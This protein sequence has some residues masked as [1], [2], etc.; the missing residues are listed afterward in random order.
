MVIASVKVWEG[1]GK[2][3]MTF[4]LDRRGGNVPI[5]GGVVEAAARNMWSGEEMITFLLSKRGGDVL[6]T[7]GVMA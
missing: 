7:K 3:I 1:S 4:L 2:E 5:T 6:F